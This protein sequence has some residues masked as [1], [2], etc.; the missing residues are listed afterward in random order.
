MNLSRTLRAALP[1]AAPV[2]AVIALPVALLIAPVPAHAMS[3][4]SDTAAR[5]FAVTSPVPGVSSALDGDVVT[6]FGHVDDGIKKR[7][8]ITSLER[9]DGVS[10]VI[11]LVKTD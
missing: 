4:S 7:R 11:S 5:V 9:L 6:V 8:L 2:A 1:F 10:R 3:A